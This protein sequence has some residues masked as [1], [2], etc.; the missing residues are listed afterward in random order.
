MASKYA[1]KTFKWP[2]LKWPK[3]KDKH[4]E[5]MQYIAA[6]AQVLQEQQEEI[7]KLKKLTNK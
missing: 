1:K 7:N 3:R 5:A 2:E 4:K 6:I